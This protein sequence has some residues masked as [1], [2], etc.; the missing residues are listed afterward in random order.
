MEAS[1]LPLILLAIPI[2]AV[3]VIAY[4]KYRETGHLPPNQGRTAVAKTAF[5]LTI[6]ALTATGIAIFMLG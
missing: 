2:T 3:F 5:M 4:K 1:L 6:A